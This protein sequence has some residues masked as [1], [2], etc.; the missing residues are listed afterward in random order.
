VVTF[1]NRW[2]DPKAI[3][4]WSQLHEFER[5]GLVLEYFRLDSQFTDLHSYSMRGL[6]RPAHDKYFGQ[7]PYADPIYAVWGRRK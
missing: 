3:R 4:L 1:S 2:F 6:E 5:M 7:I